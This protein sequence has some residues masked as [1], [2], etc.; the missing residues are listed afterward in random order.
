MVSVTMPCETETMLT[1]SD[2]WLTTQASSSVRGFTE[3]GS[4]PT[5]ISAISAGLDGFEMSKTDTRVSGVF[6][7]NRR[8]PSEDKRMGFVWAPSKLTN[9]FG[10]TC[11]ATGPIATATDRTANPS[12]A[13]SRLIYPSHNVVT[14]SFQLLKRFAHST[15]RA[16]RVSPKK[17]NES[18]R[19][20][21]EIAPVSR[22]QRRRQYTQPHVQV[23]GERSHHRDD[24]A[25]S[26]SKR[27]GLPRLC[28]SPTPAAID[29]E[30]SRWPDLFPRYIPDPA[31]AHRTKER[32]HAWQ[33][34]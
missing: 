7:A 20:T 9:A 18:L 12:S 32:R 1:L 25:E 11:A 14:A 33:P 34:V 24:N 23:F 19:K 15:L 22:R 6:K 10:G 21:A 30:E 16:I 3:T 5:G 2:S 26:P 29:V 13:L 4:M 28:G 17:G 27:R 31:G 8:V